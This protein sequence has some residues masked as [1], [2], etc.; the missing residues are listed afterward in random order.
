MPCPTPQEDAAPRLRVAHDGRG[1]GR[2]ASRSAEE[3]SAAGAGRCGADRGRQEAEAAGG[4]RPAGQS[5]MDHHRHGLPA[6][7]HVHPARRS[8]AADGAHHR[9]DG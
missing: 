2:A 6:A 7:A 1:G 9:R 4:G 5:T 8:H 3:A